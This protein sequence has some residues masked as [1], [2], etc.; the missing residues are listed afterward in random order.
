MPTFA[1]AVLPNTTGLTIG[2]SQQL[3]DINVRNLNVFGNVFGVVFPTGNGNAVALQGT[4]ISVTSP[5]L[6]QVLQFNGS[7]WVPATIPTGNAT[8][9]QGRNVLTNVPADQQAL[10]WSAASNAWLPQN[11]I[12]GGGG[13][14]LGYVV[15]TFSATP[16]FTPSPVGSCG[17]QITLSGNVTSSTFNTSGLSAGQLFKFIVI[18]DNTG[19]R[20]FSWPSQCAVKPIIGGAANQ[21]SVQSY[22]W[23]GTQLIPDSL[24]VI[25]P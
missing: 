23:N 5:L 6:N 2:S 19:G 14:S 17:F 16:V 22:I 10:V 20:T 25:Y 8:Q 18:Q 7:Q 1:D 15:T 12:G 21:T 9:I 24:V 11:Q 4:L 3:W 13:A